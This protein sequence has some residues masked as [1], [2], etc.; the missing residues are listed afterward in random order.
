MLGSSETK[1]YVI[2]GH[3][4]Y[5]LVYIEVFPKQ[6]EINIFILEKSKI[7]TKNLI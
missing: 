5:I 6:K 4:V 1:H 2:L 7:N 3:A